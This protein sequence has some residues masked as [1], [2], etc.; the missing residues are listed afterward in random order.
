MVAGEA[1]QRWT[2]KALVDAALGFATALQVAGVEPG[3]V[4]A[5]VIR[6]DPRFYP[7]YLG[8]SALGAI[9]SVLAYPNARIH[10]DKFVHGLAGM[11]R[12]SGL[13]WIL[14]ERSLEPVVRP[15]VE[16]KDTSIRGLLFPFEGRGTGGATACPF[17]S[18]PSVPCLLQHSSG[19]TGL[20]KAVVLSHR[21]V[22]EHVDAYATTLD[23]RTSDKI[24]S[25]LPLYHDMGMIAAFHLP[26]AFGIPL[27]QLDPF[28]W[29]TAPMLLL[30]AISRE[31][32]TLTWLPNFAYNLLADRVHEEELEGVHLDTV[33]LF[34]NCSEPVR[35]ES[36]RR[37][38]ERYQ[39]RGVTPDSL[40]ACYAMAETTFAATQTPLGV[41][42]RTV[43]L[44][45]NTLSRGQV[46]L[47]PEGGNARACVSSGR[48]IPG[49][50]IRVE[51]E[52]GETL[53]DASVGELVIRSATMFDGYRNNPDE[54]ARVLRDGWYHS[55]DYGFA[56]DGEYYVIGRKKDI[57]IVAGKNLYPEDI[58]D[59]VG[60]VP[61]IIPGRVVA[62]GMEDESAGTEQVCVVAESKVASAS[63]KRSLRLD[64]QCAAMAIDVTIT[65]VYLAPPRWLIKSSAGKPSRKAN[66]QR[67]LDG[68][69]APV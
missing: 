10:P 21:S 53:P 67:I 62:F 65:K 40:A 31:G 26:L 45:R 47:V 42:A 38:L 17:P 49:C 2:W 6:H 41:Q 69:L 33:R 14:T 56:L 32:A 23:L 11:A 58:E 59:E 12:R 8:I 36:H 15:L 30:D 9:P 55:G 37:F 19:T 28:E 3:Q 18:D 48:P 46:A 66:R 52:A 63:D 25:W 54:T 5:L 7:L 57:I 27:I 13:D 35:A 44:D 16:S 68:E 34:V 1:T 51:G 43:F 22:L 64:I 61:G 4:C 39:R 50:E 29:V 24:A 20:Q 60:R